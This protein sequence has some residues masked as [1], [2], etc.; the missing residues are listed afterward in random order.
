M[1]EAFVEFSRVFPS[2]TSLLI[3]GRDDGF[4]T[5]VENYIAQ[6]QLQNDIKIINGVY[7]SRF[8]YYFLADI[9]LGFPTIF[10]ETMLAS[11]EALACGTPII[12]SR[13]ADI[14]F[15]EKER[16]GWV[17]EFQ[18]ATAVEAML[19]CAQSLPALQINARETARQHFEG[20]TASEHLIQLLQELVVA[21]HS[22]TMRV[23]ANAILEKK[24]PGPAD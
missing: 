8:D 12:V 7:E 19:A 13:E 23:A 11:I 16:A 20:G 22:Y 21:K 4:Q 3:I 17:I 6:K 10:E 9:F 15:V 18:R 14:P 24:V 1:I 2:K 5:H